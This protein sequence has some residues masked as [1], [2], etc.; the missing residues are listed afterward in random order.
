MVLTLKLTL[1]FELKKLPDASKVLLN[2]LL[3]E[4]NAKIYEECC[5]SEKIVAKAEI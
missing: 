4:L 3:T 5:I 2:R 1:V